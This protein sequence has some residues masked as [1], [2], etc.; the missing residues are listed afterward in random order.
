MKNDFDAQMKKEL[1]SY[2]E[3]SSEEK[4]KIW[5]NIEKQLPEKTRS[6]RTQKPT[7][8]KKRLLLLTTMAAAALLI[9]ASQSKIGHALMDQVKVM[10]EPKKEIVQSIEGMEEEGTVNLHEGSE[11]EYII[12]IDEERYIF[13]KSEGM[14]KIV[15]KN[16]PESYPSVG[17]DIIQFTDKEPNAVLEELRAEWTDGDLDI[18]PISPIDY[19]FDALSFRVKKGNESDSEIIKYI[20]ISN[21]KKGSFVFKQYYFLEAEEGHGARMSHMLNSFKIIEKE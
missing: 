9:I 15:A 4:E 10:F 6:L 1:T 14:D 7:K 21:G 5:S 20:A 17:M 2:T 13:T 12:Y 8:K 3:I 16:H 19:P 11:A 18:T